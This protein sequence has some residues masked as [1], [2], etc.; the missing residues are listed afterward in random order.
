MLTK[1]KIHII[2]SV[3]S[4]KTTLAKRLSE[5]LG[6]PYYELDNVMW[7]RRPDGDRRRTE[8]ER[9]AV[10]GDIH[11]K[12]AWIVE[13]VHNDDWMAASF[14]EAD[15]IILLE[16]SYRVRTFRI[17]RRFL[18]QKAGLETCHY[19]PT[20]RI[21]LNMFKWS[22]SFETEGKHRFWQRCEPYRDKIEVITDSVGLYMK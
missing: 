6:I 12:Q 13:G 9:K 15:L 1:R 5:E 14:H 11:N 19:K 17:I 2:G 8:E 4:G 18:R 10:L 16:T 3:G 7:E 20:V 22:K 21:F